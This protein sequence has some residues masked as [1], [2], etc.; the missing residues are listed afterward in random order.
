[1][2]GEAREEGAEVVNEDVVEPP[3]GVQEASEVRRGEWPLL[4]VPVEGDL[5][6]V[7]W[8]LK[9]CV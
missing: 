4:A 3:L 6:V 2:R 7:W 5:D 9:D 8:A 1:M